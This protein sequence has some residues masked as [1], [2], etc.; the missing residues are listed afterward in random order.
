MLNLRITFGTKEQLS[1]SSSY[2]PFG[3][4]LLSETL[5]DARSSVSLHVIHGLGCGVDLVV[6]FVP[7]ETGKLSDVVLEPGTRGRRELDSVC[8]VFVCREPAA[9]LI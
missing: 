3:N 7:W 5:S 6:I 8:Y 2:V 9:E 1:N 4:S